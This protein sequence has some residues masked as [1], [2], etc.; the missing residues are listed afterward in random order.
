M[1]VFS[2]VLLEFLSWKW[3]FHKLCPLGIHI[4][5]RLICISDM[6]FILYHVLSKIADVDVNSI[7]TI[8]RHDINEKLLKVALNT[9]TPLLYKE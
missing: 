3:I 9:V 6:L 5:L 2:N 8:Y 1:H 7:K 4:A